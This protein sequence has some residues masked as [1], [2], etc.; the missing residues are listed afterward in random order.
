M[1]YYEGVAAK[2]RG[3][4]ARA[5]DAFRR[6]RETPVALV[7]ARPGDAK[8]LM[9]LAKADAAIA[10]KE[11]AVRGAERAVELMPV[12]ADT[13]DG[14]VVLGRLAEVYAAVGETERA[15][16][17]LQRATALPGGP[18]YGV[19]KLPEEFDP[20]RDDARFDAILAALAPTSGT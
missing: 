5:E 9:I 4:A 10:R 19:L 15:L 1:E 8:A 20:L 16:E 12:S 7:A 6:A 14:P 11:E 17:V 2:G 3:D 13:F 18:S